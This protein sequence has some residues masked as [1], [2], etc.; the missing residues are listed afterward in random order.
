[1]KYINYFLPA[2]LW[3]NVAFVCCL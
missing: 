3:Y 1:M 2:R